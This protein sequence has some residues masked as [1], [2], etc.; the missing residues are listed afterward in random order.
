MSP[1]PYRCIYCGASVNQA[2]NGI[3]DKCKEEE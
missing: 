1:L 2:F 3:C